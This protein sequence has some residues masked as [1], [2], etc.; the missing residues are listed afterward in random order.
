MTVF[1]HQDGEYVQIDGARIYYEQQGNECGFPLVFLHGGLGNI[2]TFNSLTPHLGKNYRLIGV[3]SRGQGKSTLGTSLL[4]YK[5]IQQD[6]EAVVR[7]LGVV[8]ANVI[9]HSD[10]G[11][12][13]LRSAATGQSWINK[14][15][16]IGAHWALPPDDPTRKMYAGLT[17]ARWRGLFPQ[18]VDRYLALNPEPD[19]DR[20][21]AAVQKLWLDESE[22]AYPGETVGA[23]SADVLIVRGDDDR[24]VSRANSMELAERVPGAKLLNIPFADHSVQESQPKWL[25]C[26]LDEFLKS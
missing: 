23:I 13:A 4:T 15:V 26:V 17:A 19:F 22:E 10:G 18:E 24:L 7:H 6:V 2:E 16:T 8:G 14:L 9:G 11:I 5:R 21:I 25:L 3:D 1:N 20:L 12:A